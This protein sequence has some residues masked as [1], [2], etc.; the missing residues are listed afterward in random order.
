MQP[1]TEQELLADQIIDLCRQFAQGNM[2][3]GDMQGIA[4]MIANN[5][6]TIGTSTV[7][8]LMTPKTDL[9]LERDDITTLIEALTYAQ[10]VLDMDNIMEIDTLSKIKEVLD[11]GLI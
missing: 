10:D 11:E 5:Y 9:V 7:T 8:R 3:N 6:K 1:A 2:T 4:E